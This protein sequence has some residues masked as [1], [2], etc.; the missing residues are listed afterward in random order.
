[1]VRA[2]YPR[3]GATVGRNALSISSEDE[4]SGS[5]NCKPVRLDALVRTFKN[6]ASVRTVPVSIRI[7]VDVMRTAVPQVSITII[8]VCLPPARNTLPAQP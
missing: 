6:Y 1:M 8:P 2:R 3:L 5:V 7:R 4:G